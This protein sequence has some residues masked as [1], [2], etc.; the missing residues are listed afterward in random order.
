MATTLIAIKKFSKVGFNRTEQ[1]SVTVPINFSS[2]PTKMQAKKKG[3]KNGLK[4]T[5]FAFA[6][7]KLTKIKAKYFNI[8]K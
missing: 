4:L 8:E 7:T 2:I 5:S 6:K 1:A 3:Y